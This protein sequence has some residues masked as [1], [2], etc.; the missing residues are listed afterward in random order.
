MFKQQ[1]QLEIKSIFQFPM[2]KLI[3]SNCVV[4]ISLSDTSVVT[5]VA[6]CGFIFMRKNHM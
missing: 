3:I 2:K 6:I 4:I 5:L 1:L